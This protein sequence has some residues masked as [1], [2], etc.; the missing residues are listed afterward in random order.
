M[1]KER[2][3]RTSM[4]F[5]AL[6]AAPAAAAP[7]TDSLE[8]VMAGL[9]QTGTPPAPSEVPAATTPNR[10]APDYD[11]RP[12]APA[13]A[14]ETLVWVPRVVLFPVHV[15]AEYGVR[16][17]VIGAVT[18]TE[19]HYVIPRLRRVFTSDDG[20][21]G[22]YPY[23]LIDTGLR[24]RLG[25]VGF[26]DSLGHERNDLRLTANVARTDVFSVSFQDR[27]RLAAQTA[28]VARASYGKADDNRFYGVGSDTGDAP[29]SLFFMRRRE[30]SLSLE[31]GLGGLSHAVA[32]V[33][34]RDV[35]F[36]GTTR[37][38]DEDIIAR[39][40]GEGQP[41]LPA[42][43]DGYRLLTAGA[44]VVLDS[45][46][47]DTAEPGGSGVR[48]EMDGAYSGNS[49][50]RFAEY[51]GEV[52]GFYDVSGHENVIGIRVAARLQQ[53]LGSSPVPFTER[54]TLGGNE[55]MRGF[56]T[57]HLRGD[58]AVLAEVQ[59]RYEIWMFADAE[60]FSGVG[61]TF[62][63]RFEDF[64]P[65]AL[66]WTSGLGL[67]TTFSRDSSWAMG[68]AMASNRLDSDRF[69]LANSVRFFAG[70]NKGF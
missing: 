47:P 19:E 38:T 46:R 57:G 10:T 21:R 40:G 9:D 51:G 20:K 67:R 48:L 66:Y 65:D 42:G 11:G 27:V 28:L 59:Y 12:E 16:R 36:A 2:F 50:L 15:V 69:R 43:W 23:F 49:S 64:S 56:A 32:L 52:G 63:G 55:A 37:R 60:I 61:N 8:D 53:N 22:L 54:I 44:R 13:D 6:L 4:L 3:M 39:Y 30:A 41:A 68:L 31:Q 5:L 35:R 17:P 45:R 7:A 24:P 25:A 1:L 62:A 70:L 26:A 18:W 14:V 29:G 33:G 34:A 58:S